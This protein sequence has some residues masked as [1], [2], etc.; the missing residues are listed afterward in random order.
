MSDSEIQASAQN[1]EMCTFGDGETTG[2]FGRE[3]V[4]AVFQG[5]DEGQEEEEDDGQPPPIVRVVSASIVEEAENQFGAEAQPNDD[6]DQQFDVEPE[7]EMGEH[8]QQIV[9]EVESQE[10]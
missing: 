5:E 9:Y 6:G 7:E 1:E 3:I 4:A 2:Q 8:D 10:L